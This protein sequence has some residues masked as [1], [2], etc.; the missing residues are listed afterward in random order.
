MVFSSPIF[1]FL[2]LP[3][4][5]ALYFVVPAR[6]AQP[7]AARAS[8]VFYAWGEP[9]FVAVMLVS[10]ARQLR[11]SRSRIDGRGSAAPPRASR[12][13]SSSTSASSS[14]SSTADFVGRQPEPLLGGWACRCSPSR[15]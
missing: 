3:V 14:S 11:A 8:L 4:V 1:L 5:L 12:W 13:P 7:P 6:M 9:R 2:F 15:G 10:I